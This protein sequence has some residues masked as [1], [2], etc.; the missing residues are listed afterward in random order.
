MNI[1]PKIAK[2][3]A[4]WFVVIALAI[5][6]RQE[7]WSVIKTVFF[8]VTFL[9]L[10]AIVIG[11]YWEVYRKI[12]VLSLSSQT[13]SHR[14]SIY[15][16]FIVVVFIELLGVSVGFQQMAVFINSQEGYLLQG[17]ICFIAIFLLI[18]YFYNIAFDLMKSISDHHCADD[19]LKKLGENWKYGYFVLGNFRFVFDFVAPVAAVL[20]I[21]V[22]YIYS[23]ESFLVAFKLHVNGTLTDFWTNLDKLAWF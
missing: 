19:E 7:I 18:E 22:L 21:L 6:F 14:R 23:L 1:E 20:Y 16:V 15:Y 17:L 3:I 5:I 4:I 10:G 12:G 11:I 2:K 8:L 13:L 9:A